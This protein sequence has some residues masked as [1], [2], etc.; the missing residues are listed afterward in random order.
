MK[1]IGSIE[2]F[3]VEDNEVIRYCLRNFLKKIPDFTL[4]GEAPDGESALEAIK[5]LKPSIALVDI[6]LPGLSGIEV[7]KAI[8]K[9]DPE[10]RV[11]I[12]TA[13]DNQ[14][15]IF[16]SLDAGADGYVLKG[17]FSVNLEMAIRSVKVGSVWLDPGIARQVLQM[18]QRQLTPTVERALQPIAHLSKLEE[19]VLNGVATSNC[20]DGVCLVDPT[21]LRK[22]K[23][24]SQTG[25]H[26]AVEPPRKST[27]SSS[28]G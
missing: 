8:K 26:P 22:L 17:E 6:G 11:L 1:E 27:L 9:F 23:R 20:K 21:F 16:D 19:D 24:F 5:R 3:F 7:T 14:N 28:E 12:L 10:L 25:N 18:T 2:I 13:S 15:D 4:V